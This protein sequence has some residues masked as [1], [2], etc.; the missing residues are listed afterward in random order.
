MHD[1][2]LFMFWCVSWRENIIILLSLCLYC[3]VTISD[4][5]FVV[6]CDLGTYLINLKMLLIY[7]HHLLMIVECGL[8]SIYTCIHAPDYQNVV[9]CHVNNA[10]IRN[11]L[12]CQ[13]AKMLT[14]LHSSLEF[15]HS[16][17]VHVLFHV[18]IPECCLLPSIL[19]LLLSL[20][21]SSNIHYWVEWLW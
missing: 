9:G 2:W 14:L 17:A 3:Y 4:D 6:S 20:W 12:L 13:H 21:Y 15:A 10:V 8:L 1:S 16:M 5:F 19:C 7:N 18:C 11:Y